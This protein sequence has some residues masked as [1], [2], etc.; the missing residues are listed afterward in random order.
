MQDQ[1]TFERFEQVREKE[2]Q[3]QQ[4]RVD[5]AMYAQL[6][7]EDIRTKAAREEEEEKK[8]IRANQEMVEVLQKQMAAVEAHRLMEEALVQEEAQLLV[9]RC[10]MGYNPNNPFSRTNAAVCLCLFTG[11]D[12]HVTKHMTVEV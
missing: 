9:S 3:E 6:W 2:H 1:I 4:R 12:D 5:D 8:K 10:L 11:R 7:Y